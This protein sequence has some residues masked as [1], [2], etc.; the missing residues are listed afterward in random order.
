MKHEVT[1]FASGA[2]IG[3]KS[4]VYHMKLP[5]LVSPCGLSHEDSSSAFR[6]YRNSV[7]VT[8]PLKGAVTCYAITGAITG[9]NGVG[10]L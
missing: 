1:G 5:V 2:G 8:A 9:Q 4:V 7:T 10:V 3:L 6:V